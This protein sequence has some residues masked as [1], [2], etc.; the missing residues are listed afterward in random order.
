MSQYN[1]R[2][3]LL[4]IIQDLKA[5]VQSLANTQ[6]TPTYTTAT[7][8]G[9]RAAGTIIFVSDA[10][11]GSKFQGWDGASWVSLG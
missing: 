3:D 9:T 1:E 11:A 8:P 2:P 4:R 10:S 6:A 5:R 7:R